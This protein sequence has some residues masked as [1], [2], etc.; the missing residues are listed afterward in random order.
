MKRALT[1]GR[2]MKSLAVL[3]YRDG[4]TRRGLTSRFNCHHDLFSSDGGT[5]SVCTS[6]VWMRRRPLSP[7]FRI[8]TTLQPNPS[9]SFRT[10]ST[11]TD[12]SVSGIPESSPHLNDQRSSMLQQTTSRLNEAPVGSLDDQLW[13]EA[14]YSI[15]AWM[16]PSTDKAFVAQGLS[17]SLILLDRLLQE[18]IYCMITKVEKEDSSTTAPQQL[19]IPTFFQTNLLNLVVNHWRKCIQNGELDLSKEISS[20]V[21]YTELHPKKLL[22][23]IFRYQEASKHLQPDFQTFAMVLDA[24]S[25]LVTVSSSVSANAILSGLKPDKESDLMVLVDDIMERL[26]DNARGMD[27]SDEFPN[28]MRP[29]VVVFSSAMNA[30]VKSGRVEAP[31]K[32]EDLLKQM[33]MLHQAFPQLEDMKPNQVTYGTAIDAWAKFGDVAKV[34]ELMQEMNLESRNTG[35]EAMKPGIMAFTGYLVA[36]SKQGRMDEAEDVLRQMED[37]YES[38]EL[39]EPPSV[40]SYSTVLDGYA[41]STEPGAPLRAE[42]LLR[43]MLDKHRNGVSAVAPNAVSF[44]SVIFSHMKSGNIQAAESLLRQMHDEYI[45]SGNKDIRPTLE[46]YSSVMSGLSRTRRRDAGERAEKLFHDVKNMA[47]SGDLDKAPDLVLYNTVLDCWAK[48]SGS[49]SPDK[50]KCFLDTM[51]ADGVTP[52]VISFNTVIHSMANAGRFREAEDMLE[53]M[54]EVGVQPNTVTFNTVLSAYVSAVSSKSK[55]GKVSPSDKENLTERIQRLFDDLKK[56]RRDMLDVVTYN[57][58]LNFYSHA[59]DPEK[60]IDLLEEMLAPNSCVPPD[61]FS[62]NTVIS[63]WA[64]SGQEDAPE[65]AEAVF[66][67]VLPQNREQRQILPNTVTFNSVMSTWTKSRRPEAAERC[68]HLFDLMMMDNIHVEPDNVTFN[69]LIHA[70]SLSPDEKAPEHAE[71]A[72]GKMKRR[73][74]DGD[75]RFFSNARTFGALINVWSKSKRP[76][77][78]EMAEF[79]LRLLIQN[80]GEQRNVREM[81]RVHEFTCTI[82]AWANSSDPRAPYKADE[83]LFLLL[84]QVEQGNEYAMP[85]KRLFGAVLSTLA[86]SGVPNKALYADKLVRMMVKFNIRPN[87]YLLELLKQCHLTNSIQSEDAKK[88]LSRSI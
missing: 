27:S 68:Q 43:E 69:I 42:S 86:F 36:L 6:S 15:L 65:R 57:T 74:D 11:A 59:G 33:K 52:D 5:M 8:P 62:L 46:T 73:C 10:F 20:S 1:S 29:N 85:D 9:S 54:K 16:E 58:V 56:N 39:D 44:N 30:W 3:G 64:N 21:E 35:D 25:S 22:R 88:V 40:V 51:I 17:Q 70:W 32:V 50:A 79:Y 82:R 2:S 14:H 75:D 49:K 24:I 76:N 31:S 28:P 87:D 45:R 84:Q 19:S 37:L 55:K 77:A 38:G 72:Y 4:T 60:A 18:E 47:R 61:V 66:N 34:Q 63:A 71:R 53:E 13:S 67:Q 12:E 41:R 83:I 26:I 23:R 81:P 78:G 48:S 80:S 7:V